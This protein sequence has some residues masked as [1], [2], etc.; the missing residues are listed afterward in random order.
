MALKPTFRPATLA[1]AAALAVLADIAA[2]GL[3][4]RVWLDQAGPGQ[5]ALEVGRQSVRRPEEVDSYCNATIAMVGAEVAACLIGG[6]PEDLF[7]VSRL[8]EKADVFRPVVRLAAQA[9]GTWYID[10]IASFAE[11]R[12]YG[13]GSKLLTVAASKAEETGAVGNSLVVGSWNASAE[14]LYRRCGFVPVA[15]EP[16]ILPDTYPQSGDWILMRRPLT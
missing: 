10:V 6:L 4:N 14:R 1:D 5:S 2:N 15:R 11:F 16:A 12:G 8:D 9:A 3:A 13:L 7:D